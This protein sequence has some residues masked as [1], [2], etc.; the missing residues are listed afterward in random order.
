MAAT[1]A[2]RPIVAQAPLRLKFIAEA[3]FRK[4]EATIWQEK[5]AAGE[6]PPLR[7]GEVVCFISTNRRQIVFVQAPREWHTASSLD[8]QV[9]ASRRL[10]LT[11]GGWNPLM[12]K[13]YAEEV[14]LVLDGLR[15]FE[16]HFRESQALRRGAGEIPDD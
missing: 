14:G 7:P 15:R 13:N 9:F 8:C 4:S 1:A 10:R 16:E 11:R 12:L 3:D 2:T 5:A 6:L